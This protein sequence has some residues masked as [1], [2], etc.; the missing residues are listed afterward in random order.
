MG[1]DILVSIACITYNHEK[2]IAKALDGFLE[3]DFNGRI[4]IL[5]NDDASTDRTPDIIREYQSKYPDIIKPMLHKE[6]QYQKGVTN[7][8][9]TFNFPRAAGKYIAMCEGDDYWIDKTKLQKQVE[10]LEQNQDCSFCFHSAKI[11]QMGRAITD[12]MMR[13]YT[14]SGKISQTE[15]I[16]KTVGYPTAS[17]LFQSSVVKDL[18]IYYFDCPIGDIPLQLILAKYGKGYYLD[19]PMSVYRIGDQTSW[20]S[21]EKRGDFLQKQ[22]R[23]FLQMQSMYTEYEKDAPKEYANSIQS[24]I[25]RMRF[26]T[27]VNTKQFPYVFSKENRSYFKELNTRTRFFLHLEH[28]LPWLY[29]VL[30]RMWG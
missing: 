12:S 2:Y 8:S 3:Q 6:N 20:T 5:I 21:M 13:P 24:A 26:L 25:R 19:M 10:I 9:G 27:Y 18:P 23:Y 14:K 17:L 1:E 11:L 28:R 29:D 16:D 4:E 7:P 22:E 15:V 30:K